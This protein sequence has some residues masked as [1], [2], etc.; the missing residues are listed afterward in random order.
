MLRAVHLHRTCL[1]N[2]KLTSPRRPMTTI[3]KPQKYE[4]IDGCKV[5]V[6]DAADDFTPEELKDFL[7]ALHNPGPEDYALDEVAWKE[8]GNPP[9]K[10]SFFRLRR[11][12]VI[13]K[14]LPP[15]V[16]K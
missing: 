11:N 15:W 12:G 8:A 14:E 4:T 7:K 3:T 6:T 9:D 10:L 2:L 5:P 13:T 1:A 16:I